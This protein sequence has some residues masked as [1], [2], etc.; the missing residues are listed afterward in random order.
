MHCRFIRR[1]NLKKVNWSTFCNDIDKIIATIPAPSDHYNDFVDLV[2][3]TAPMPRECKKEYIPGL[4]DESSDLPVL[5][6]HDEEYY[7]EPFSEYTIQLGDTQLHDIFD[8]R[9][10]TWREILEN[11]N[12]TKNSKKH[13][14]TMSTLTWSLI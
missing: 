4:S 8:E 13:G 5:K 12:L 10:K 11:P 6:L 7:D 9:R 3:K 2:K 14:H 1:F